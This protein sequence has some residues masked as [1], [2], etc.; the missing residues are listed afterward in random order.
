LGFLIGEMAF[1]LSSGVRQRTPVSD[2][3]GGVGGGV[4]NRTSPG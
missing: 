4:G 1:L 3:L 2:P